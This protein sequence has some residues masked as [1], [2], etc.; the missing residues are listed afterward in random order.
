MR[1]A[2]AVLLTLLAVGP[3]LPAQ[4]A[5]SETAASPIALHGCLLGIVSGRTTGEQP[6][7]GD[8][9]DFVLGE[10][11]VRFD[12]SG[13]TKSGAGIALVKLDLFHDAI[14]NSVD[15]D[16]REAY[17]GYTKGPLDVQLGRQIITWGVGDLFFIDD[18]FPKDW[19]SFF[20][21]RPAEYLKLGVDAVRARYSADMMNGEFVVIPFFF[22][23]DTLPS[24]ERFIFF[25]PFAAVPNRREV[26]PASRLSNTELALRLYRQVWDFDVS[27]YAYR[28][29]W[30]DPSARVD[31]PVSPATVTRFF[32][33]LSVYGAS[34]QRGLFAGVLSLEGGYYDSRQD[35]SG[36]DQTIPNSQWRLL[37]GY[38][39]ELWEDFVAGVQG[40][41]EIM[42]SYG[43]YRHALPA[44]M[45]PQDEFRGVG[46]IRL[47]QLLDYQTWRLSVFAAYSPTDADYFL[48]P[49]ASYKLTD[50]LSVALGA[51]IFAG[52][53]PTTFFGQFE[54][55]D[56]VYAR[57][58]FD[59]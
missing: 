13:T 23:P 19:N 59:L 11:R 56:N 16:L 50:Q 5:D 48:Q 37:A 1:I 21:G 35:R 40:Y 31:N 52:Q 34:A 4:A 44:G 22:T 28:G 46:S 32:P 33:P 20:S 18:V 6:P 17:A 43:A 27:L 42:A 29:F 57:V 14:D 53:R 49:E 7:G 24:P 41:A 10:E 25:D 26:L 54:R 38:Q 30:R 12:L 2:R 36:D 55:D 3:A 45:P 58:R 15:V 8:S 39:R 9:G 47:T 51:N